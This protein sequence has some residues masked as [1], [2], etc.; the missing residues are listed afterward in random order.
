MAL[1]HEYMKHRSG[2][3]FGVGVCWV[4]VFT[5]SPG[6]APVVVC[7]EL[8]GSLDGMS[9]QIAAEVIK[10]HFD[11]ALPKL[12]VPLLWIERRP[13]R[14]RGPTKYFL[15]TFPSY[16]PRPV[17]AGFVRRLTLGTPRREPLSRREVA[18]LTGEDV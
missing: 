15:L 6:D 8:A 12:P 7:E 14:R 5:G 11:G 10:E 16:E 4:R 3:S 17:A 2:Y 13:P 1:T 18:V 9:S